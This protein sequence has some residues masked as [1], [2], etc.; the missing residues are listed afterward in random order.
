VNL[1]ESFR[2][3]VEFQEKTLIRF[4]RSR[5]TVEEHRKSHTVPPDLGKSSDAIGDQ[6]VQS[7]TGTFLFARKTEPYEGAIERS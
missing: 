3:L 6:I 5:D 4:A 7:D 2:P 1:C